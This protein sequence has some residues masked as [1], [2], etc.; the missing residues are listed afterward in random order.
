VTSWNYIGHDPKEFHH[1]GGMAQDFYAAFG[2][3]E[4]GTIGTETTINSGD[5]TAILM[6]GLKGLDA[7][8]QKDRRTI[9]SQAAKLEQQTARIAELERQTAEIA[10]LK[11]Q[12]AKVGELL[13][14]LSPGSR[15]TRATEPTIR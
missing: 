1:Y 12:V 5:I 8:T 10:T 2:R 3:D 11:Q 13:K 4:V 14:A 6:L 9:A 15:A 7:Q